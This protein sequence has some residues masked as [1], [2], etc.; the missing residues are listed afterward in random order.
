MDEE[1]PTKL[2]ALLET[3]GVGWLLAEDRDARLSQIALE[4]GQLSDE[5]SRR[6]APTKIDALGEM[7]SEPLA[8]KPLIQMFASP[9]S[10]TMRAMVYCVL[11]GMEIVA[12]DFRYQLKQTVDLTVSVQHD[13]SGQK[14]VF[15]SD[16]V[17]DAEILRHLGIMM[18]GKKPVLHGFY[19]FAS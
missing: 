10:C 8:L 15:T 1:N 2:A 18:M 11:R 16:L 13:V 9:T 4:I 17:W 19:A 5:L 7:M 12:I 3:C 6:L 14:L